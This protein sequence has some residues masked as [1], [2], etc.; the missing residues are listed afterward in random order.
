MIRLRILQYSMLAVLLT[1]MIG[2]DE[3]IPS[4]SELSCTQ[5]TEC[6]EDQICDNGECVDQVLGCTQDEDCAEGFLCEEGVCVNEMSPACTQDEDCAEGFLCEEGVC[7]AQMDPACTQDQDCDEGFLCEDGVC[8]AEMRPV[9]TQDQDCA[10]R[11]RC[12]EGMCVAEVGPACTQDEDCADRYMC[13]NGVCVAEMRPTCTQDQECTDGFLCEEGVCVA[14]I[15]S[16]CTQD[17]DCS[18]GFM[19]EEGMCVAEIRQECTQNQDCDDGFRCEDGVCLPDLAELSVL[20][21]LDG[22]LTHEAVS[23]QVWVDN[24]IVASELTNANGEVSLEVPRSDLSIDLSREG[25]VSARFD[26]S[27]DEDNDVFLFEDNPINAP[28]ILILANADGDSIPDLDDNCP[29]VDNEGQEDFDGDGIGDT[30]D[31]DDDNDNIIDTGDNCLLVSNPEQIDTDADNEGNACDLDDDNDTILDTDDNCELISN[32]IQGDAD[33]DGIGNACD[34]D[35]PGIT[36]VGMIDFSAV[37]LTDRSQIRVLI[38]EQELDLDQTGAFTFIHGLPEPGPFTLS[39]TGPD[40]LPLTFQ[41]TAPDG[42]AIV[43][44]D[45]I[46]LQGPSDQ[47]GDNIPDAYDNCPNRPNESQANQDQDQFGD[48]CDNDLDNDTILNY[49]DNCEDTYNPLQGDANGDREGNACDEDTPGIDVIGGVNFAAVP[50]A[51]PN[52]AMILVNGQPAEI[53]VLSPG[54]L[55]FELAAGLSEPGIFTVRVIWPGFAPMTLFNNAQDN[56]REVWL[57]TI[58]LQALDGV[59]TPLSVSARLE[60]ALSH[61]GIFVEALVN[62]EVIAH[63]FTGSS[64]DVVLDV[65]LSDVTLRLSKE[66]FLTHISDLT[67]DANT[68]AFTV[69]NEAINQP[70]ILS[71]ARGVVNVTVVTNQDWVPLAQLPVTVTI[72]KLNQAYQSTLE[73]GRASFSDVEP[74]QYVLQATAPGFEV[75]QLLIQLTEEDLEIDV[76]LTLTLASISGLGLNLTNLDLSNA[77]FTDVIV[78]SLTECPALLPEE[79]VCRAQPAVNGYVL[80]GPGVKIHSHYRY[81]LND[82]DMSGV[83]L[84]GAEFRESSFWNVDLRGANLT[85]AQFRGINLFN[86]DFRGANLSNTRLSS[87]LGGAKLY[88]LTGSCPQSSRFYSCIVQPETNTLALVGPD[89]DLN[90]A[91]LGGANLSGVKTFD[92]LNGCPSTLPT[93]WVCRLQV[94]TD[95]FVLLGSGANLNNANLRESDLSNADLSGANLNNAN[96]RESDLSNTDLS[97]ANLHEANLRD[98]DLS[99]TNLSNADMRRASLSG[100]HTIN[101]PGEC[102]SSLPN[103]WYCRAQPAVNGVVIVGVGANLSGADLS[104]VD[105]SNTRPYDLIEG[106]PAVLPE[107]WICREQPEIGFVLIG[108]DADLGSANLR[109]VRA[110]GFTGACPSS[111][112]SVRVCLDLPTVD[113]FVILGPYADLSGLDFT[114]FDFTDIRLYGANLSGTN[115]SDADLSYGTFSWADLSEANLS[116]ARTSRLLGQ[117]PS[118]LPENWDCLPRGDSSVVLFGPGA[119]LS[120][121]SLGEVDLSDRDLRG[122]NIFGADLSEAQLEN[123]KAYDLVRGCPSN[124]PPDWA[125]QA[126]PATDRFFLYGPSIDLSNADLSGV[127]LSNADLRGANLTGTNLSGVDLRYANLIEANLSDANLSEANLISAK[128][129]RARFRNAILHG[130]RTLA[131]YERRETGCPN[132]L[133]VDWACA[134]VLARTILIGPGANL[135]GARLRDTTFNSP[136]EEADLRGLKTYNLTGSCPTRMPLNWECRPQPA[137]NGYLLLGPEVNLNGADLSGVD[138]S[139][140]NLDGSDFS[141]LDFSGLSFINTRLRTVDLSNADLSDTDLSQT[142]FS[143]ANLS[144]ANLSRANLTNAWVVAA[145]LTNANLSDADLNSANLRRTDLSGAELSRSDLTEAD[146]QGSNPF[147]LVGECP[148]LLPENWI[149][150]ADPILNRVSLLG[151]GQDLRGAD[152]SDFD[153]SEV[154]LNGAKTYNL[155]GSCPLALPEGWLCIAQPAVDGFALVGPHV[156]LR[157]ADLSDADLSNANLDFAITYELSGRC[158]SSLPANWMCREQ[159]I[160]DTIILLG[161]N[162]VLTVNSSSNYYSANLEGIH[163]GGLSGCP[164]ELNVRWQCVE[165]PANNSFVL[166][167]IGADLS[168][169]DLRGINLSDLDLRGANLSGVDLRGANVSNLRLSVSDLSNAR[170]HDLVGGCPADLP[171]RMTCLAQPAVNGF[172]IF[173]PGVNL[174]EANLAG[175]NLEG[176]RFSGTDLNGFDFNGQDLS[177]AHL[178]NADLGGAR[179][180]GLQGGCPISLPESWVCREQPAVNGYVLLGPEADLS[181]ADLEGVDLNGVNLSFANLSGVDLGVGASLNNVDLGGADLSDINLSGVKTHTLVGLCPATLPEEW[182]CRS[183]VLFG[184]G[185]DLSGLNFQ[186]SDLSNL[187]LRL[188]D[189]SNTTL[190]RTDLSESNVYEADFTGASL[191]NTR[192]HSLR[193]GCPFGLPENWECRPQPAVNGFVVLGEGHWRNRNSGSNLENADLSN[194]DLSNSNLTRANLTGANL[195]NANLNDAI[196]ESATMDRV[197]LRG[198]QVNNTYLGGAYLYDAKTY[199]LSGELLAEPYNWDRYQYPNE[200]RWVL[201]GPGDTLYGTILPGADLRGANL[202]GLNLQGASLKGVRT[203]N[204]SGDCPTQLPTGYECRDQPAV[205]GLMIVGPY[206]DLRDADLSNADL[207][208][209]NFGN[210]DTDYSLGWNLSGATHDSTICPDVTMSDVHINNTCENNVAFITHHSSMQFTLNGSI[211]PDSAKW[212]RPSETCEAEPGANHPFETFTIVNTAGTDR[213]ITITA[214]WL[215]DGY[216]HVFRPVFDGTTNQCVVGNN[217]FNNALSSQISNVNIP[218]GEA[219][220]IVASTSGANMFIGDYSL[221][222]DMN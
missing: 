78:H 98:S 202:T 192:L 148:S 217:N 99:N 36:I 102:P 167:G 34:Q 116:N 213:Q 27:Y 12:E 128:I 149:C 72:N 150:T 131:L 157:E 91:R 104:D 181:D 23:V 85:D 111:L 80:L 190:H 146:L 89:L 69:D 168:D 37:P 162:A 100:A 65:P 60:D 186:N 210:T 31:L 127:D 110:V 203:S 218:S 200:D 18:N 117:C 96:L 165:V 42:E 212:A 124:L 191:Y 144:N 103:N 53:R 154:N 158:P 166:I 26:L 81:D 48:S 118:A 3:G 16:E 43:E 122:A 32:L 215:S 201:I 138:F 17:Q 94:A 22:R 140:L 185:A 145:N 151:E 29:L 119:N 50:N 88:D 108:P 120:I 25:F 1:T 40:F 188:A 6:D 142:N 132:E 61:G 173:G 35:T 7:L 208:L 126:Q 164:A 171:D 196:L 129:G 147:D 222:V 90:G 172:L 152:L 113:G 137:V 87:T 41:L 45:T 125:C 74:G 180:Y 134:I 183:E 44:I 64:G 159:P 204:L 97:E 155:E 123:V 20:V 216:L 47:D 189:L 71:P 206:V 83:N 163:T 198:A 46:S 130:A 106:C 187:N 28:F 214:Q 178:M 170:T 121:S 107:H 68:E 156:D 59:R 176:V 205:S 79:W 211:T 95:R 199:D 63:A 70:F 219:I 76:T 160:N 13:E 105:L 112:S 66:G 11:Y 177:N 182:T 161:P 38:E 19:C 52:Q 39:I 169:L 207:S 84:T 21:R 179:T 195:R 14:E 2:C 24:E 9:C 33:S 77:D 54:R 51:D 133:P 143:E 109:G 115:L 8:E 220:I 57:P 10:Y 82:V 209:V 49:L 30:C 15:R 139:E 73:A 194:A 62:D 4:T 75:E 5:N 221:T 141:G 193:E 93:G 67:Y 114:G 174:N 184:P 56:R 58:T 153:L 136:W 55:R 135:T 197:D 86:A 175:V 101:H 92:L